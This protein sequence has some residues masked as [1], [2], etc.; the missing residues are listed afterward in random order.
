MISS[1]FVFIISISLFISAIFL[2]LE[3]T[4]LL[5]FLMMFSMFIMIVEHNK[6]KKIKVVSKSPKKFKAKCVH[7]IYDCDICISQ[8]N[9]LSQNE[10]IIRKTGGE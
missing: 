8:P 10:N 9:C 1:I 3:T 2:T 6:Y 5:C 4:V 7:T